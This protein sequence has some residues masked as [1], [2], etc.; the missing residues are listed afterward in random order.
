MTM[1][2][3]DRYQGPLSATLW[4]PT[5]NEPE[6]VAWNTPEVCSNSSLATVIIGTAVAVIDEA[7]AMAPA[8]TSR[9]KWSTCQVEY[10]NDT[11]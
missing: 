7:L 11:R 4:K 6:L 3:M 2:S 8:F 10:Q 9:L 1:S 5:K